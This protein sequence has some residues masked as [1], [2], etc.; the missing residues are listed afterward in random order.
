M[1]KPVW[2]KRYNA[3]WKLIGEKPLNISDENN[4]NIEC[5]PDI[6]TAESENAVKANEDASEIGK[7]SIQ[8]FTKTCDPYTPGLDNKWGRTKWYPW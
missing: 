8:M 6:G 3:K 2:P 1:L 5:I 7:K 4:D